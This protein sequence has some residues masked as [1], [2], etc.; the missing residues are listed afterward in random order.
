MY[1]EILKK[2]KNDIE[3][4]LNIDILR[5]MYKIHNAKNIKRCIRKQF[6]NKNVTNKKIKKNTIIMLWYS[7]FVNIYMLYTYI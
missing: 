6:G 4:L 1:D 7:K 3:V 2:K 5:S